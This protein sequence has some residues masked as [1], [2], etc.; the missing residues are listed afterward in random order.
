MQ[1]VQVNWE[2]GEQVPYKVRTLRSSWNL[3]SSGWGQQ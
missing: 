1:T 2:A 3:L